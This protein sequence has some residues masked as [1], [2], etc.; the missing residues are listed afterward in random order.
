MLKYK[1]RCIKIFKS[2]LEEISIQ[3][4]QHHPGSGEEHSTS[5][6]Q[7]PGVYYR[8]ANKEVI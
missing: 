5:G 7:R 8:E 3:I 6:S 1:L 4:G 2:L